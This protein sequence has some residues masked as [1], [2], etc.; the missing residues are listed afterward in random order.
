M[1]LQLLTISFN[2]NINTSVQPGD[3]L[4]YTPL[5]SGG[6][7]SNMQ[8]ANTSSI[9]KLG[10]ISHVDFVNNTVGVTYDP[11]PDGV[12]SSGD[13]I[14][15]PSAGDYIMFEKDKIVNSSSLIG[16]YASIDFINN[17]DTKHAELFSVGCEVS[18]S[19]K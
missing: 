6:G 14:A 17:K 3:I 19:S 2:N 4:Y 18:E 7:G 10:M 16:Y 13:E 1:P 12:P 5:S 9:V 11:D 15:A 8:V